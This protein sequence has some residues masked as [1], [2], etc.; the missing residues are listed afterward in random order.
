MATASTLIS[1]EEYLRTGY[2]PDCDFVDGQIEERNVGERDHNRLQIVLGAWFL[3]HEKEWNIYVLPEQR[4]RVSSSRVRI[5]D[6]CLLRGDAPNEQV[7]TT[8]PLLCVEILSPDDRL[9]RTAKI[10]D[11][12]ARMGVPNLWILDPKDRVAYDYSSDG[13]LRLTTDRLS[14]PNTEIFVDLPILFA[15]LD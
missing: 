4:T 12:Y 1:I 11:E 3:A 8:P 7:L 13:V 2:R 10:M 5:P 15:T 6:V 9:P 14:I